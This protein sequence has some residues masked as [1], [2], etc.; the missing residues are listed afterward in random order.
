MLLWRHA[1]SLGGTRPPRRL[2]SGWLLFPPALKKLGDAPAVRVP[3]Y[4]GPFV[5]LSR[6]LLCW[7][8]RTRVTPS[9]STAS[10]LVCSSRARSPASSSERLRP[11]CSGASTSRMVRVVGLWLVSAPAG[12]TTSPL[13][14]FSVSPLSWVSLCLGNGCVGGRGSWPSRPPQ[15]PSRGR[16]GRKHAC[17]SVTTAGGPG[18]AAREAQPSDSRVTRSPRSVAMAPAPPSGVAP[19]LPQ[20]AI[21]RC[22]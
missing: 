13:R 17:R 14:C 16:H 7:C 12:S 1:P 6:G 11:L 10:P 5:N 20:G 4:L 21:K 19:R 9:G 2:M 22:P 3:G 18:Q 15:A 8:S